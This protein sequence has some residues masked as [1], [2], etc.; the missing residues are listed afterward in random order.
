MPM[1]KSARRVT[2]ALQHAAWEEDEKQ[3]A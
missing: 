1:G 2:H 3:Q